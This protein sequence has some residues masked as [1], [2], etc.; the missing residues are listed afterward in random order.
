MFPISQRAAANGGLT[1][2][3]LQVLSTLTRIDDA[4]LLRQFDE[5]DI[6]VVTETVE[7]DFLT[8]GR[9]VERAYRTVIAELGKRTSLFRDE[10]E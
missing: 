9:D 2:L 7:D 8:V 6:R 4:C 3:V 10:I 5:D 1:R